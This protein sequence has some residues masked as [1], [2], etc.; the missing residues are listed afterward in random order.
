MDHTKKE[1]PFVL[2]EKEAEGM[3]LPDA[4]GQALSSVLSVAQQ[5]PFLGPS[6]A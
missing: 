4:A 1:A 2:K 5:V 3:I 6:V